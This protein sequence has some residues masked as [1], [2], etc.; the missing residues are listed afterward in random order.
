MS[1]WP[2]SRS[3]TFPYSAPM[4]RAVGIAL[5]W[6]GRA[7]VLLA[8]FVGVCSLFLPA[9]VQWLNPVAC[10]KGLAL[11]NARYTLPNA[12]HNAKLELVCTSPSYTESAAHKIILIC[13]TL[14]TLGLIALYFSERIPRQRHRVP[15]R[16]PVT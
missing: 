15:A 3:D 13:V 4:E 7:F 5:R 11:D 12:P 2:L 16:P 9:G 6:A 8:V 10:P 14:V 1:R